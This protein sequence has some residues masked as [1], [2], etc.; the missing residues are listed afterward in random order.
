[1]A[2]PTHPDGH[3][4][5]DREDALLRIPAL[6]RTDDPDTWAE[7]FE[8][9]RSTTATAALGITLVQAAPDRMVMEM[10]ITDAVRQPYGLLHGGAS[11]LLAETV[12]SF[13]ACWGQDL[14]RVSP[15]GIE[16]NISHLHAVRSGHVRASGRVLRRTRHTVVHE[17]EIVHVETGRL[18]AVARVTNLLRPVDAAASR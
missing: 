11:A 14:A 18:V 12:A 10:P 5:P 13:H 17:V 8:A 1:M 2:D 9:V 6:G 3:A 4:G 7:V 16:L 15:V